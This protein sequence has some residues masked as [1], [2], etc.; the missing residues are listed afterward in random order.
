MN[1]IT[2]GKA[3]VGKLIPEKLNIVTRDL[4]T[5]HLDQ[6]LTNEEMK[7]NIIFLT[8]AAD[9]GFNVIFN[10]AWT[11]FYVVVN[12]SGQIATLKNAAGATVAVA[13][14]AVG[15]V[16]NDGTNI[17]TLSGLSGTAV[18]LA[19][20]QTLINKTLTAPIINGALYGSLNE[21]AKD[22]AA[23]HA[24]ITLTATERMTDV[25]KLTGVGDGG[26]NLILNVD[27]KKMYL[28]D[29]QSGQAC[30]VMNA[31]GTTTVVATG[32]R[33]IVWNDGT[34]VVRITADA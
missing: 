32:K 23:G 14:S 19:G 3:L 15:I 10:V 31:A 34:N 2:K 6:T 16:M 1:R 9:A 28:I 5:G 20:V 24:D 4:G 7:C 29:N 17:V 13:D 30:T 21:V 11:N 8:G 27:T 12:E 22:I 26:F 33:A 18:T 25:V